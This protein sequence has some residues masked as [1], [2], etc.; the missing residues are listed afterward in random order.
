M[1]YFPINSRNFSGNL[2]LVI[3]FPLQM[4]IKE[5]MMCYF[6]GGRLMRRGMS[7][8][9]SLRKG[10]RGMILVIDV[11]ERKNDNTMMRVLK[12]KLKIRRYFHEMLI[13]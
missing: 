8:L 13:V 11:D 3:V 6:D 9:M 10:I 12:L 5:V 2:D 7:D 1:I 4:I